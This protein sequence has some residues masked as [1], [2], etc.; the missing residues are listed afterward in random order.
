MALL[1]SKQF[2]ALVRLHKNLKKVEQVQKVTIISLTDGESNP[3][4]FARKID[5]S[6]DY[7]GREYKNTY[8]CHQISKVFI[9]RDPVTGYSRKINPSAYYTTRE[10]VSFYREITDYNW[11][12]IRICNKGELTRL[13]RYFD[14]QVDE[15]AI[16]KQWRKDKFASLKNVAG[17]AE[18]FY[19]P[20]KNTGMGTAEINVNQK[21]EVAT[22]SEL[23]RAFKSIWV[24]QMM[25]KT[26]L[27]CIHRP[28]RIVAHGVVTPHTHLL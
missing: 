22:K 10:I 27:W 28:D 21:S 6:N 4:M 26:V 19:M 1:W 3:M 16:D 20:D 23:T 7:L 25:N 13:I 24:L 12:G 8:L 5:S 15:G 17:F 11:V 18:S 14:I 9:L 2:F